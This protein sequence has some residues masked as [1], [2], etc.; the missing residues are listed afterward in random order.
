MPLLAEC[1]STLSWLV[2]VIKVGK[3]S[4]FEYHYIKVGDKKA[5]CYI[6]QN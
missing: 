3:E 5:L 4:M 1:P 2:K 6:R